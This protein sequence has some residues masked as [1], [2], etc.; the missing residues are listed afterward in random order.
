MFAYIRAYVR[1]VFGRTYRIFKIHNSRW[2]KY[3]LTVGFY[4]KHGFQAV[5][6]DDD[7][8]SQSQLAKGHYV[9]QK[10]HDDDDSVRHV[11]RG[12]ATYANDGHRRSVRLGG[13]VS[14]STSCVAA[15]ESFASG[16]AVGAL[17]PCIV[18]V[19]LVEWHFLEAGDAASRCRA[20]RR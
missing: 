8:D 2:T 4:A 12:V 16:V 20:G 6:H 17:P 14:D 13:L 15:G 1:C 5:A 9:Q 3:P 19:P 18:R 11:R 10:A 7:D